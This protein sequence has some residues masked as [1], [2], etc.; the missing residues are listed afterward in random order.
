M[1]VQGALVF[2]AAAER[3]GLAGVTP[4]GLR[5][6]AA[7][8]AVQAGAHVRLVQQMLGHSSPTV[9]LN[10]YSHLFD[11][12]LDLVADRLNTA[13]I[14]SD[15]DQVRTNRPVTELRAITGEDGSAV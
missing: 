14:S 2:D 7:T 1:P 6:T 11:A 3:A 8:L 12:D 9:T 15:A 13:K 4:H 5:H 10:V